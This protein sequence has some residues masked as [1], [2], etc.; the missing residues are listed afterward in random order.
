MRDHDNATFHMGKSCR[1]LIRFLLDEPKNEATISNICKKFHLNP[2]IFRLE[3][4][5]QLHKIRALKYNMN[6]ETLS[7][8][9]NYLQLMKAIRKSLRQVKKSFY[10]SRRFEGKIYEKAARSYNPTKFWDEIISFLYSS[11]FL[12]RFLIQHFLAYT[13]IDFGPL[14]SKYTNETLNWTTR[15]DLYKQSTYGTIQKYHLIG[16]SNPELHELLKNV[17]DNSIFSKELKEKNFSKN[18]LQLSELLNILT[19]DEKE[20]G[21]H[22]NLPSIYPWNLDMESINLVLNEDFCHR[23]QRELNINL[24]NPISKI[25]LINFL[26]ALKKDTQDNSF[27]V[28]YSLAETLNDFCNNTYSIISTNFDSPKN[29]DIP[30]FF[31]V[32]FNDHNTVGSILWA[33]QKIPKVIELMPYDWFCKVISK[34]IYTTNLISAT[35]G[36]NFSEDNSVIFVHSPFVAESIFVTARNFGMSIDIIQIESGLLLKFNNRDYRRMG[37]INNNKFQEPTRDIEIEGLAYEILDEVL[38]TRPKV[39]ILIAKLAK[40]IE[41]NPSFLRAFIKKNLNTL[42]TS[43]PTIISP[44]EDPWLTFH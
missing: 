34:A 29:Y 7:I 12:S 30:I 41:V 16:F 6:T 25:D 24:K 36:T 22:L 14:G 21:Y 5:D 43:F 18:A 40:K 44:Q 8:S 31:P 32:D 28:N 13:I 17:K 3:I 2:T 4:N 19:F 37:H 39:G 35:I 26:S 33:L 20:K 27:E 11:D 1:K 15:I 23:I 38:R 42:D 9:D 10:V